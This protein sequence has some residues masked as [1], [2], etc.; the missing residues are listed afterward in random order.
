MTQCYSYFNNRWKHVKM[1]RYFVWLESYNKCVYSATQQ[2]SQYC[3][4]T[5]HVTV[6]MLNFQNEF[7]KMEGGHIYVRQDFLWVSCILCV[8][9]IFWIKIYYVFGKI[10]FKFWISA[11]IHP[12]RIKKYQFKYNNLSDSRSFKWN[13]HTNQYFFVSNLVCSEK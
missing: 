3:T 1:H 2:C 5:M 8:S 13:V 11:E 10:C 7:A 4:A 9:L 6:R 12:S